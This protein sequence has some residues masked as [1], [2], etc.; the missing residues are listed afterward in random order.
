LG[1]PFFDRS[2]QAGGQRALSLVSF[3]RD[4]K[5]IAICETWAGDYDSSKFERMG[6]EVDSRET[7]FADAVRDFVEDL[8]EEKEGK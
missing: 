8:N 1:V 2:E 5:V 6:F 7:G 4:P 3:A